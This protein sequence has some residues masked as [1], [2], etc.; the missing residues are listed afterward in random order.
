MQV[1]GRQTLQVK[2]AEGVTDSRIKNRGPCPVCKQY[3]P[4]LKLGPFIKHR[5]YCTEDISQREVSCSPPD[6]YIDSHPSKKRHPCSFL[7]EGFEQTDNPKAY[8]PV[9]PAEKPYE[10]KLFSKVDSPKKDLTAH[11]L[12]IRTR[13][14]P[15][16][17]KLCDKAFRQTSHLISHVRTHTGEK[18]YACKLCNKAF[19][20]SGHLTVHLRIHTGEKPYSCKECNKSFGRKRGLTLHQRT[21]TGEKPFA[22]KQCKKCFA[23][24]AS[25]T[26]HRRTHTGEKPFKC[27]WCKI[28]FAQQFNLKRHMIKCCKKPL[29]SVDSAPV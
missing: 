11:L 26:R 4:E 22:C 16:A 29:S 3:L 25:L 7:S 13:E 17:C 14:R 10:R 9:D 12:R 23:F 24:P 8:W 28:A 19:N 27:N 20:Q 15:Y 21:H 1:S 18:P 2:T 6:R 5:Y